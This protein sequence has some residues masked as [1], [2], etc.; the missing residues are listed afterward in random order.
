M[1]R[2]KPAKTGKA[3]RSGD[4]A[5]RS[6]EIPQLRAWQ[7]AGLSRIAGIDEV[8][9]GPLAGPVVAAAVILP[10]GPPMA[11]LADSKALTA[12]RREEL[13][14]I[15]FGT[16][17]IGIATATAAEIDELNI[18][19]ATLLAMR[20][21]LKALPRPAEAALVDGKFVPPGLTIPAAA[22]IGGDARIAAISAASIIAKVTRD[23]MMVEAEK[24]FPGYGFARNAGYPAPL[25]KT[26]LA[27][28]GLTRIHRLSYAPC[29]AIA[30]LR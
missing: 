22:V 2:S 21:A 6:G 23:A 15:L 20:R 3:P 7:H 18:H 24:R 5:P 8:G 14:E 13:A 12:R 17:E 27:M 28:L 1:A 19:G 10:E 9:R 29:R 30:P 11:G 16:A 25:H 4:K 26:A